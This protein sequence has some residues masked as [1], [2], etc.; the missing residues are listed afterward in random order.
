M[1]EAFEEARGGPP[2]V[3]VVDADI[4]MR[5]AADKT[6]PLAIKRRCIQHLGQ[7]LKKN[8]AGVLGSS[9][10]VSYAEKLCREPAVGMDHKIA[11]RCCPRHQRIL[12][13]R[14]KVSLHEGSSEYP[15]GGPMQ[16]YFNWSICYELSSSSNATVTSFIASVLPPTLTAEQLDF[17]ADLAPHHRFVGCTLLVNAIIY[18]QYYVLAN[19][20]LHA[21]YT[22]KNR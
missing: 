11:R 16:I 19:G 1:L 13:G 21:M 14:T 7:N 2:Y 5:S 9:L 18:Q 3:M 20:D 12:R 6:F 22:C 10:P 15:G 17:I 8:L 4:A